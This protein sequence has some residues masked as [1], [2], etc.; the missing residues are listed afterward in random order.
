MIKAILRKILGAK[1]PS[2]LPITAPV[3]PNHVQRATISR[4]IDGDTVEVLLPSEKNPRKNTKHRVR[5]IGADAPEMRG[6]ERKYGQKAK[7]FTKRYCT[8]GTTVW[9]VRV[10]GAANDGNPTDAHRRL[11]RH[12]WVAQPQTTQ[13]AMQ[14]AMLGA[15]LLE[16]GLANVVPASFANSHRDFFVRLEQQARRARRGV[17]KVKRT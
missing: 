12:V 15:M 1:K 14:R 7:D 2:F 16:A 13:N 9:L 3:D 8:K 17:W 6:I 4:V 11:R 5:M 10:P